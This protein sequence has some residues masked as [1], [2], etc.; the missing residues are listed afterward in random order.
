MT[1]RTRM[2]PSPTGEYHIGHIRTLLYNYAWAKNNK[3]R[4][5]LRIEDTD[6]ERLVE[7]AVDRILAV[8]RDYGLSYDEGPRVGGPFAPYYQSE[9]LP[10]YQ[11]YAKQLVDQGLA[12]YCFCSKERLE[13][14][15]KKQ[16]AEGKLPGYDRHCRNLKPAEVKHKFAANESYVIRLKIPDG[17]EISFTDVV[18]G[19]IKV[20]SGSLDDQILLKSD[21]FPT[22]HLAVVVDDH[23]MEI[24]HIIRGN[25]WLSSTP[26]HILL[27][28]AFGWEPPTFVHLPVFLDP[29]G[30]GKMS[31]RRGSVSARSFLENGYLPEAI[32]NYLMLLGW[33]PG[34]DREIFSLEEFTKTFDLKNL[35]KANPRF[36][37]DKLNWFNQQYLRAMDYENLAERLL[38]FSTYNKGEIVRVLPLIRDRLITLKEFDDQAG[39]FFHPPAVDRKSLSGF[40]SA[41]RILEHAASVLSEKLDGKF[42]EEKAREYCAS[43]GLKVGDYFMVLR[44]AITGRTATPPLGEI[45]QILGEAETIK[46]LKANSY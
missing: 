23:L 31:K 15:R 3:G 11:K 28:R 16:Q 29:A 26:K 40:K 17:E 30:E 9:R 22:Y 14:L 32:L 33:N 7:G 35:N 18:M 5:I 36:T 12:Y 46:R 41:D 13:A 21:G 4:F 25:E 37:F 19:K 42:L 2:A 1:V 8:I 45:I 43:H 27:Y 44:I 34:N 10:I 38:K 20:N 6:R 24:T 39:Y